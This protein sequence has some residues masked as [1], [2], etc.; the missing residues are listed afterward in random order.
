MLTRLIYLLKSI[1][2]AGELARY[3]AGNFIQ[4]A[5]GKRNA[6]VF[7]YRRN[8]TE[9]EWLDATKLDKRRSVYIDRLNELTS[10]Y[11]ISTPRLILHYLRNGTP[12][13]NYYGYRMNRHFDRIGTSPKNLKKAYESSAFMYANR[14]MLRY[15]TYSKGQRVLEL[16]AR[17]SL[18]PN[19]L[20][21]LD[22]GC[23]VADISLFLA[24]NGAQ[25]TIVDLADSK[26][27]FAQ[28]RFAQRGLGV[29]AIAASQTEIPVDLGPETFDLIIMAE[30][31]EHV[32]NPRLFLEYG[33]EHLEENGVLYDSLGPVHVHG[34]G[35]DHLQEA[36]E[37]MDSSDYA[38]FFAQHLL[39]VDLYLET[40]RYPCFYIKTSP[41]SPTG[42]TCT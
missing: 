27:E 41:S 20:R 42:L 11:G 28:W 34:T 29:R 9:A 16:A 13:T 19:D 32:R 1:H 30:F 18:N 22:Y 24:L 15:H 31:L 26:F 37:Q 35:N 2:G 25:V 12:N 17:L 4:R 3:M 40:G 8:F 38:E 10:F 7:S 33:L 23:G 14:L 39:S 5:G 36:K 6:T 21:V